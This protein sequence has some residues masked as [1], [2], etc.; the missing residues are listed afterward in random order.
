[1]DGGGGAPVKEITGGCK[2][3]GP[4]CHRHGRVEKQ[5]LHR[6]VK[7]VKNAFSFAILCRGVRTR[8]AHKGAV[9]C[10]EGGRGVVDK[11]RAVI[12]LK[13]LNG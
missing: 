10:E 5:G 8:E 6:V 2:G 13:A 3:L 7:G 11:L 1:V 4:I 12:S 9:G